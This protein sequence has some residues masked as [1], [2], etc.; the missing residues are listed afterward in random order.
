[1]RKAFILLLI[2]VLFGFSVLRAEQVFE[3]NGVFEKGFHYY[4]LSV[5]SR[6]ANNPKGEMHYLTEAFDVFQE[7]LLS[8]AA[9]DNKSLL[10][11]WV[12][13]TRLQ[14]LRVTFP[15]P[16]QSALENYVKSEYKDQFVTLEK[17]DALTSNAT[18]RSDKKRALEELR[19]MAERFQQ[20]ARVLLVQAWEEKAK[21]NYREA[22]AKLQLSL[23]TWYLLETQNVL[24]ECLQLVL[25]SEQ[26]QNAYTDAITNKAYAQALDILKK[27][28]PNVWSA[29]DIETKENNI[30]RLW[31]SNLYNLAEENLEKRKLQT[32]RRLIDES[33]LVCFTEK[34]NTL[35]KKIQIRQRKRAFFMDMGYPGNFNITE[36]NYSRTI[37]IPVVAEVTN[38]NTITSADYSKN[39]S[40]EMG[41]LY[42]LTPV[43]GFRASITSIREYWK[44]NTDYAF[45]WKWLDATS[46]S[47][48]NSMS[49]N[50]RC[51][52]LLISLDYF[53]QKNIKQDWYANFYLGPTFYHANLDAFAGIGY[54]SIFIHY[55]D[56]LYYPE[57][58]PFKYRNHD[59]DFGL[60]ANIGG[61]VEWKFP[62]ASIFLEGQYYFIPVKKKNWRLVEQFYTGAMGIFDVAEPSTLPD[63]PQYFM[64]LNLST[65]KIVM[66]VRVY[67]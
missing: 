27:Q 56:Q 16:Y 32:A 17:I 15:F 19:R 54:G 53:Y 34:A 25:K 52:A 26:C 4:L 5:K 9:T 46:V 1:M 50:A 51:T 63:L 21:L 35:K 30:K 36:T 66:G 65:F 38:E 61:G 57:W 44:M 41:L 37:T 59:S 23:N 14:I 12:I 3:P 60:G 67:F 45:L 39:T 31:S 8:S 55:Q 48:R 62:P 2:L 22:V 11:S 20:A 47:S 49:E 42:L 28:A 7:M 64:K 13:Y 18:T 24:T 10:M 58:F 40:Y 29:E 33:L 6:L 43:S